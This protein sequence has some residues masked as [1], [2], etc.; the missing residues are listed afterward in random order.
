MKKS[1]YIAGALVLAA[2]LVIGESPWSIAAAGAMIAAA[3]VIQIVA[4]RK[5]RK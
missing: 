2:C 1:L 4:E 5:G 3:W